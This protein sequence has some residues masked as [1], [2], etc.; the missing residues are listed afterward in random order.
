MVSWPIAFGKAAYHGGAGRM[1]QSKAVHLTSKMRK[2]EGLGSHKPLGGHVP[3]DQKT[4]HCVP[5][6]RFHPILPS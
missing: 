3:Y 1:W 4:T 5:L 6:S 2:E